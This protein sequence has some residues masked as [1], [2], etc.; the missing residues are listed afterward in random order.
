MKKFYLLAVLTA[1]LCC[2]VQAKWQM[3][4]SPLMTKWASEIDINNPLPEYPRPQLVREQWLNLNG[5][6]QFQSGTETDQ[7]PSGKT[8][9]DEI[10]VPFAMESAISGVMAHHERSWYR[11]VFTVPMSWSGKEVILHLGAVDWESEVFINGKSVILH[12]G[13]YDP[14]SVNITPYLNNTDQQELIVRVYDPTDNRGYPRGKQ[15][16]HTGGIMY[17]SVSG[18][19]QSVW[20]EPVAG[21]GVS[22]LKMTPDIDTARLNLRVN[23]FTDKGQTVNIIV[24]DNNKT[25][26]TLSGKANTDLAVAI[27]D[28]KLWSPDNPFLYD[29][30][31]SVQ[32]D[33]KEVDMVKSYFGMRKS[34][35]GRENGVLKMFLNN[36]FVF[37]MGPLDQGWW[38]DGLYT[39]PTDE[40]LKFDIIK[41]K[42]FGFNMTRKHIKVEPARWYYWADKLGLMVWQDM[43]SV[44]SYTS[45]PQPIETEQFKLELNRMIDNLWNCPSIIS[46]VVF[47][48][49]QGIHNVKEL[50]DMVKAKDPSRLVNCNSG[51]D[52]ATEGDIF[53]VHSYPPPSYPNPANEN[54]NKMAR[55]CGEYGGIGYIYENRLWN[56]NRDIMEYSS[57]TDVEEF[58][59]RY[60]QY[61]TSLLDFKVNQGL[62]AAVYTEITDVENETNGLMTYDR[63]VKVSESRVAD[64]NKML[65]HGDLK[66]RI[67]MPNA[68]EKASQWAYTTIKPASDWFKPDFNDSNWKRGQGGFG[69]ENTPNAAIGTKWNT[70]D[71]WLRK[72]FKLESCTPE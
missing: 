59:R 16:L 33:G 28:Q 6:W 15:T 50:V 70:S 7:V 60:K 64:L 19:W 48:E 12:Q 11:R 20:L 69:A 46:W 62:S 17:T 55:V 30:E 23:T 8:L 57:V 18:I 39:A 4:Q 22:N 71:I 68:R 3:K 45:R 25:V 10:L 37:Q 44:N 58:F 40:A 36:Q 1:L 38:P 65:I 31:V 9:S 51:T 49:S 42:E 5:L 61:N 43:P 14:I 21:D 26:T 47:N 72:S 56:P 66:T 63:V 32:A 67:V 41:T 27:P 2:Q 24:K 53:D 29:L 54:T 52:N 35:L 34:S 13:G